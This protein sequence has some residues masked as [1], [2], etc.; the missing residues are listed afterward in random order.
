MTSPAP[1]P[2]LLA[3]RYRWL[4][5]GL[6]FLAITIN[7]IDRQIL[8][9]IKEILDREIGWTNTQFGLVNSAFAFA[10]AFG[11]LGFGWF[12]DRFG[13]KLGL[14]V[15]ISAWSLA[16]LGHAFVFSFGGFLA[17]RIA[18]GLGEGGGFPSAIKATALWFPKRERAFATSLFNS[19]TN[20]GA[21]AAPALVPWIALTWGWHMAF[22]LAGLAGFLWL[23]VWI[24]LYDTPARLAR[25]SS[26]ERAHI[27]SD[28][29]EPAPGAARLSWRQLLSYRQ[30]WGY[31]LAKFLTDPI[32]LFLLIWLPDYFKATRGLAIKQS[33]VHLVAIY[34][35]IT[36]LSIL[37]GWVT[38]HLTTRG[39]S[40][41]RARKTGM[42]VFALLVLPILAATSV[43]DWPAVF[44]IALAGSAHQAW[45]AN[46]FT[47][48]SDI[49]PKDAIG[50]VVGLGGMAGMAGATLFPVVSG[51]ILDTAKTAG[52]VTAGYGV[53]F[54]ICASAYLLAFGL[55]H[56]FAPSFT[57]LKLPA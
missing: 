11:L 48:V 30:T 39:W 18:L 17:A 33:W 13:T 43:G 28:H 52:N 47:T 46:L 41:T 55:H 3:G 5:C 6:L 1:A 31:L 50:S 44:L 49:F 21:I 51:W 10:Y 35:I 23:L 38:G 2:S 36:V 15:S 56:W 19:G 12:V 9:L 42:F 32:W 14:T 24:P 57:P 26:A 45:S 20:V 40:V 54:G 8:S 37:G 22:I 53:L 25:L 7:Y 29:D 34:A 16:A 4:V 27:A